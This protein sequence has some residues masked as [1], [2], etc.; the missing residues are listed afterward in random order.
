M[1]QIL[2]GREGLPATATAESGCTESGYS[3][4]IILCESKINIG[5][6][7]I[8][9]QKYSGIFAAVLSFSFSNRSM[10]HPINKLDGVLFQNCAPTFASSSDFFFF[11]LSVSTAFSILAF[12]SGSPRDREVW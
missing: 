6:L 2:R 1:S 3:I 9:A 12:K 10:P 5:D 4:I 8:E 11:S 7:S